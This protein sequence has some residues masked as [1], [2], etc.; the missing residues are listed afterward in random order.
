MIGKMDE[1]KL[2]EWKKTLADSG[3]TYE[4]DEEYQETFYNL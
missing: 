1:K 3:V 2:A 4:T